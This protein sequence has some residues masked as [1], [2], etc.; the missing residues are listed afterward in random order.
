MVSILPVTHFCLFH[1]HIIAILH[2]NE[3][4]NRKSKKTTDGH[5]YYSVSYAKFKLGDEV[6]REVPVPPTYGNM[7]SFNL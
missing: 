5:T 2:F 6:V 1:R 7:F 3:N 4:L